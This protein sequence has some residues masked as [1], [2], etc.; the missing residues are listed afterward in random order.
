MKRLIAFSSV[1]HMGFVML[2]IATLTDFGINAADLRHGRP[3]PHHRHA[4]LRRRLDAGALRHPRDEPARR[5]AHAGAATWAGSSAS[6]PWRRSAC[7]A[8][9]GSGAS[10]RRSSRRTSPTLPDRAV[11][12]R[13]DGTLWTFRTYMVIAAIGTVLA[14][15]Y[16]LW[17]FQRVAMGKAEAGVRG[18]PHPRR[19]RARVD[20]VDAAARSASSCSASTPTSSSRSPTAAVTHLVTRH[21]EGADS[22]NSALSTSTRSRRRSSSPRRSSSC[23]SP[24]SSGRDASRFTVVAASRRSA[25]SPR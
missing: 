19:A 8:S 15:G 14:A 4:L 25:C 3:R 9:P 24:T 21:V 1:A 10:S 2:G 13:L 6:A 7:P 23:C 20:R 16:L 12:R 17:M 18:R 5:P 11:R 22:V